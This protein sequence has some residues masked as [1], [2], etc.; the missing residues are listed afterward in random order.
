MSDKFKIQNKPPE[1]SPDN[2]GTGHVFKTAFSDGDKTWEEKIN[3]VACLAEVLDEGHPDYSLHESWIVLSNDIIF[4]P[5]I[6]SLDPLEDGGV[7]TATTIEIA[8][9]KKIPKGIF[10]YQHATGDTIKESVIKGFKGWLQMDLAAIIDAVSDTITECS[11]LKMRFPDREND[12]VVLLGPIM[13]YAEEDIDIEEEHPFCRC[14][15]FTNN[16]KAFEKL[17]A[18]DDIYGIRFFAARDQNGQI[19]ADCR[20]NGIDF[21]AGKKALIAY[22]STWPDRGLEFRK[23]YVVMKSIK[24]DPDKNT[25]NE[26]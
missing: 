2:P 11:S 17:I 14:C 20:I 21:E 25:G 7:S 23:Q 3:L 22:G 15:L 12:R 18:D 13:Y 24:K 1:L 16:F 4:Q 6:V 10:E 9:G 26:D 19:E 5:Q 8:H